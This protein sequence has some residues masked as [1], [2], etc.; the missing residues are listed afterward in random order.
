[1]WPFTLK[2]SAVTPLNEKQLKQLIKILIIDDNKPEEIIDYVKEAGWKA[3]YLGDLDN[4]INTQLVQAHIIF[5]DIM[6]PGKLLRLANGQELAVAIKKKYPEKKIIIYSTVSEQNIFHE[7]ID[8]VDKRIRRQGT[9]I[10]FVSAIE[11][12]A[13]N[14]LNYDDAIQYCYFKIKPIFGNNISLEEFKMAVHGSKKQNS[15]DVQKLIKR[16]AIAV[17]AAKLVYAMMKP[18]LDAGAAK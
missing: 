2:N 15:I 18:A 12:M 1:M 4:L 8:I 3:K 16:T 11:E 10:P 7:S 6:G 13:A 5:I 17:E 14:T 9:P